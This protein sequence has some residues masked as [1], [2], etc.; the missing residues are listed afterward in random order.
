[1]VMPISSATAVSSFFMTS[2]RIGSNCCSIRGVPFSRSWIPPPDLVEELLPGSEEI[3]D[4]RAYQQDGGGNVK[5][6]IP[7]TG[8]LDDEAGDGWR[9]NAGDRRGGVR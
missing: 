4:Y 3:P 2:T 5:D 7:I 9:Q 1:M 8:K 6:R